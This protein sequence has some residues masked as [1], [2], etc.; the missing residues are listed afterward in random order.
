MKNKKPKRDRPAEPSSPNPQDAVQEQER[1]AE[2]VALRETEA[3]ATLIVLTGERLDPRRYEMYKRDLERIL[4][5]T[6][7]QA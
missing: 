5:E 6:Y 7:R 4:L 3:I 2:Q 1:Q